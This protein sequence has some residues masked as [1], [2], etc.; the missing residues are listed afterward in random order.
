MQPFGIYLNSQHPESDDPGLR[1]AE[2]LEQVRLIRSLGFDSI[3]AGEHHRHPGLPHYFRATGVAAAHRRRGRGAMDRYQCDFACSHFDN[4]IE[5]AEVGAFMDDVITGGRF[6]LGIGLGYR[7]EEY[8]MFGVQMAERASRLAEGVEIIRRCGE[9]TASRIAGDTGNSATP[10]FGRDRCSRHR[11]P[12]LSARAGGGGNR[13]AS[14]QN[15]R[16]LA[17]WP[18]P[19]LTARLSWRRR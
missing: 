13:Q 11:R 17:C 19:T 9:R 18:L 16:W 6:L 2:I 7:S 4:P 15:R 3:W 5:L 8:N 14:S 10:P 12:S 1:F